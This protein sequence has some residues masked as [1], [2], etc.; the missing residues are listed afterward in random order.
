MFGK[1]KSWY[2][3]AGKALLFAGLLYK[4]AGMFKGSSEKKAG[5]KVKK[6]KKSTTIY[7][8]RKILKA[9]RS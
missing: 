3:T 5:L 4:V 2:R 6:R 9:L 7:D 8:I 1:K